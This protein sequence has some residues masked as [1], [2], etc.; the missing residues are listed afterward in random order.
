MSEYNFVVNPNDS[1]K[2]ETTI[3]LD[4]ST[5]KNGA[6]YKT[7]VTATLSATDD[8]TGISETQYRING[9]QWTTYQSAITFTHDGT[10]NIEYKSC[11]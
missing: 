8:H 4:S 11:G 1:V 7:N 3:T 10:F 5:P 6:W 9:G 2:P